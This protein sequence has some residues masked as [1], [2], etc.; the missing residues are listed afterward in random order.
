MTGLVKDFHSL[1]IDRQTSDE[2]KE[3]NLLTNL[4]RQFEKTYILSSKKSQPSTI[5][6]P[7]SRQLIHN[8]KKRIALVLR[9]QSKNLTRPLEDI[10]KD[11]SSLSNIH[12]IF[13]DESIPLNTN[14][15]FSLKLDNLKILDMSDSFNPKNECQ[16]IRELFLSPKFRHLEMIGFRNCLLKQPSFL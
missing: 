1:F 3:I 11:F 16:F 10:L 4:W 12:Y 14:F 7:K 5:Y 9:F 13:Y 6:V 15:L 8:I 2:F